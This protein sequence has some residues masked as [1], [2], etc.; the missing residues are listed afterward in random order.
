M[1]EY[2]EALSAAKPIGG[3]SGGG[4][5]RLGLAQRKLGDAKRALEIV[6][7]KCV[8]QILRSHSV[9]VSSTIGA[10]GSTLR[11]YASVENVRFS[12]VLVDEAAQCTESGQK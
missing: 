3:G 6:E 9:V 8:T 2:T 10:G 4:G 1:T 5:E 12:T 7:Q 11:D